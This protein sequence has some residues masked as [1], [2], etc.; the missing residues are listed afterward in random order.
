MTP[1]ETIYSRFQKTVSLYPD[2]EA[3]AVMHDGAYEP[4]TYR[5][6]DEK[7]RRFSFTLVEHGFKARDKL[8]ILVDNSI[9]WV[10]ADLA[11]AHLGIIVIPLH[12]S[13]NEHYVEQVITH[14]GLK[15][16]VV[17]GQ[18]VAKID[19]VLR[20][21]HLE[22]V[23]LIGNLHSFKNVEHVHDLHELLSEE[24]G[25]P[26]E[27]A[28]QS[29]AVHTIVYTS[30][31]TGTPKGVM[32]S[33]TNLLSN[34]DA[35]TKAIPIF[36]T[37]R[38]FSFLPLSH[39]LERTAGLYVPLLTGASIYYARSPK[40]LAEDMRLAKPTIV[41]SVPRVFERVHE[42][43]LAK[44]SKNALTQQIAN[45]AMR[46][47]R[48]VRHNSATFL[49]NALRPVFDRL[50]FAK[51]REA[52]G[53]RLRIAISGGA[54]LP[55]H[56]GE[57]FD[58]MGIPILEGYG[59]TETAPVV[60]VNTMEH[61]KFGTVGK[62]LNGVSVRI[63]QNGEILVKGPNVMQG[64]YAAEDLTKEVI[65]TEGWFHTGDI[66]SL[67]DA[68]FLTIIGRLKEMIVL[69]TGRNIFPVPIEQELE[70]SPYIKQAMVYGDAQRHI[71]A[72]IVP[73][74]GE[75]KIW[76][77]AQG[78]HYEIP[79][80]LT[81]VVVLDMYRAEIKKCLVRMQSFEQIEHFKLLPQ[82]F[83]VE[84]D[85]MTLTLKLRRKNIFDFYKESNDQF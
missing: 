27:T 47:A 37:D 66:G 72:F 34:I 63:S 81:D 9:E 23:Y 8:G 49:D 14:S 13:Y 61:R 84:N 38:F 30:G 55:K 20:S 41:L 39:I 79:A 7:I 59:L 56:I 10:T 1:Q 69:S 50:V 35:M 54:A 83:T 74:F 51:V 32:L 64:Y 26:S 33:H 18:Q 24:K 44:F 31:T 40:T 22:R 48:N 62:A 46:V 5:D 58:E 68:G 21:L 76:C 43:I 52:F 65:D 29:D 75:L 78:I 28:A 19:V 3:L 77:E 53:G 11:C 2:N 45:K 85:M 4:I 71:S 57:F 73:D 36:S 67:D 60:T 25:V 6:L 82:E 17:S 12:T 80:I 16:I 15:H 70:E 42:K